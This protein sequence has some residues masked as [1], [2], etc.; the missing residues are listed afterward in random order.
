GDSMTQR[1]ATEQIA[2]DKP[3]KNFT[4]LLVS[5]WLTGN[6]SSLSDCR[7]LLVP[8]LVTTSTGS[9]ARRLFPGDLSLI[10]S[11][12]LASQ[13]DT[14]FLFFDLSVPRVCSLYPS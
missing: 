1:R 8:G 4:P 6:C 10:G 14:S 9:P 3:H 2:A 13:R 12:I 11:F 7:V 5:N